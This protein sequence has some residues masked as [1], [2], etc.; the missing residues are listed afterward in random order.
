M[1]KLM[2][3][4]MVIIIILMAIPLIAG[5]VI[6]KTDVYT[7]DSWTHVQDYYG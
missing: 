6:A 4:G 1:K 2:A 5:N 3:F 7:Y